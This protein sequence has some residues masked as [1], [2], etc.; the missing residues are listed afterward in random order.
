[1]AVEEGETVLM[2]ILQDMQAV[3]VVVV[4]ELVLHTPQLVEPH[5]LAKDSQVVEM[6]AIMPQHIQQAV[7][8]APAEL[9]VMPLVIPKAVTAA[10]D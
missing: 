4:A 1:M 9:V 8:V 10:L 7:V 2:Q 3:Q 6:A 5:I